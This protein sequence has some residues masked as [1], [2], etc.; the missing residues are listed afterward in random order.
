MGGR[1]ELADSTPPGCGLLAQSRE[2]GSLARDGDASGGQVV[3][4]R[5][6]IVLTRHPAPCVCTSDLHGPPTVAGDSSGIPPLPGESLHRGQ[7]LP[8][9]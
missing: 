1:V 6:C 2:R 5:P 7:R 3:L 9:R 4:A 8:S